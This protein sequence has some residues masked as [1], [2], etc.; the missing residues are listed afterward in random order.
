ML[1]LVLYGIRTHQRL[2]EQTHLLFSVTLQGQPISFGTAITLD[3]Q[4]AI[5]GQRIAIGS[6]KFVVNHP[7]GEPF[8]TNWFMWYG[9]HDLGTIDLKRAKG[10]LVVTADPPTPLLSI[11]GPEWSVTLANSSGM[12][13]SVPADQ[14]VVESKYAHWEH[15]DDVFVSAGSTVPWRIAPR[16][17]TVQLSC[18]YSNTTFQLLTLNNRPVESGEFPSLITELPEGNYKLVAQ[19]NGHERRQTVAVKA[20]AT[21]DNLVEYAFGTAFLAT[22]PSG[23]SVQDGE[24][25]DLGVTPL[26]LLELPPGTLQVIVHR[27]GYEPI[28]VSL[29]INVDQNTIFQTNLIST[30]YT[31]GMKSARQYMAATEYDHALQ[32]V[33]D[34]L[35]AKPGDEEAITLQR[36]ATGLGKI[37]HAKILAQKGDYIGGGKELTLALQSLPDNE[38]AKQLLLE[39]KPHEPEQIEHERVERLNRGKV[40]FDAFLKGYVGDADLFD[41]YELKTTKAL[42]DVQTNLVSWL[43]TKPAFHIFKNAS[44][45]PETFEIEA[46]QESSTYLGTSSGRRQCLIVGAQTKDDETQ[47]LYKVLEYRTE[48]QTKF[49]IG[50]LIHAPVAVNYIP[51]HASGNI[52]L[53]DKLQAQINE[54]VSNVTARIQG[55]IGQVPTGQ[56]NVAK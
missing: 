25:R 37:Q 1:V 29:E 49:S 3:G 36:N 6:H 40:T 20:G 41:S 15:S 46:V 39:Y 33:G 8:S 47:I 32:A 16:L 38:E 45:A 13:S 2:C 9:E 50:A 24:G 28:A 27:P 56:P 43:G 51:I 19:H 5:S 42:K 17:G 12:T 54:G 7:K 55:A 53:S 4:P 35:I 34:A 14:Y 30:S 23:A 10:M 18:N 11:R 26:K 31:G 22:G 52:P 21:S 48:A 44:T